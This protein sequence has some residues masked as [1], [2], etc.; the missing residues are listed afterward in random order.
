MFF[1]SKMMPEHFD[2][3]RIYKRKQYYLNVFSVN[4]VSNVIS[5]INV[6]SVSNFRGFGSSIFN[7]MENSFSI[8]SICTWIEFVFVG[9]KFRID[10]QN[11]EKAG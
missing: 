8:M 9:T 1:C 3:N 7:G 5:L 11:R 6:I 10:Q 4:S 2:K